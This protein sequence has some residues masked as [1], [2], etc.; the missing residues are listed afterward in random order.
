MI[1][2]LACRIAPPH[3]VV[4]QHGSASRIALTLFA[5]LWLAAS[6]RAAEILLPIEVIGATAPVTRTVTVTTSAQAT[7]LSLRVHGLAH[8]DSGEVRIDDG[9]WI[10][11]KNTTATA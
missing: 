2:L 11:L 7:T 4:R 5:G 6:A 8:A 9:N 10:A 1:F 3:L